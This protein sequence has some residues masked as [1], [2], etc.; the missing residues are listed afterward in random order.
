MT[1]HLGSAGSTRGLALSTV[2]AST[3]TSSRHFHNVY[4]KLI[5]AG[6]G[7][8]GL[9]MLWPVGGARAHSKA[10]TRGSRK[11]RFADVRMLMV[12]SAK[13]YGGRIRRM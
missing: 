5:L 2:F 9:V 7:G 6:V 8:L 13:K 11:G 12:T 3:T 4:A 1:A 10:L